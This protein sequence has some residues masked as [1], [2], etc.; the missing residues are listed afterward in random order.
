[1]LK[2]VAQ[3][4]ALLAYVLTNCPLD[5]KLLD[6]SVCAL[7]NPDIIGLDLTLYFS[8]FFVVCLL[9]KVFIHFF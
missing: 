9:G 8:S 4:L 7:N 1:M 2:T 6:R 3:C 5:P